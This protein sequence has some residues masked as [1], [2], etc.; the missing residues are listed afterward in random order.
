MKNNQQTFEELTISFEKHT[1]FLDVDGTLAPDGSMDFSPEVVRKVRELALH[2]QV[3][4]C[5]NRRD[6]ARWRQLEALLS[7][8]VV[9]KRHRKPSVRVLEDA[10]DT[11]GRPRVVIGD[12]FLTDG[13]FAR[14]IGA[15]FIRVKR[16]LSGRESV[17]VRI[18]NGIDDA[19]SFLAV[20]RN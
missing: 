19:V 14:R 6:P 15:T 11:G 5:T 10:G 17:S 9:T 20:H 3:L 16:K 4:L 13:L 8:P 1:V 7:L 12:K 2:N 18:S